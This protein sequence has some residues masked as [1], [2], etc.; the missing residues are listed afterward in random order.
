MSSSWLDPLH[1]WLQRNATQLGLRRGPLQITSLVNPSG[2]LANV[3]CTVTDGHTRLHVKLTDEREPITRSYQL[4][5]HLLAHHAPPIL[6]FIDLGDRVGTV[7]PSIPT[8]PAAEATEA[9]LPALVAAADA[10][11]ADTLLA[12]ALPEQPATLGEAF[13]DLWIDRFTSDLGELQADGLVPPF[14]SADT[15]TWMQTETAR[16]TDATAAPLF[17]APA[18]SPT[19]NDLHLDNVLVQPDGRFWI[20]DWDEMSRGDPAIDL[21]IL[22]SGPVLR[23]DPVAPMLGP[24]DPAFL[25]RFA[26][27]ARA[28]LL[29][30]VV[31]SL[32][33]WAHA[34]DAPAHAAEA[35][36][37]HKRATHEHGLALYRD[38][39][40]RP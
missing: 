30:D 19:H 32:A 1:G 17:D 40:R 27:C 18:V 36:R 9:L 23:G 16:L 29:D 26:L 3:A 8:A 37:T 31:D 4:R 15:L 6:A 11:H 25:A 13:R 7:T 38:R 35:I 10:L 34:G 21:A 39:Y 33:D 2:W 20:V 28:V 12:R 22:L 5:D 14:V 24:R